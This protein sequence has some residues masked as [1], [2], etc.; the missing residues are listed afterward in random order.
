MNFLFLFLVVMGIFAVS[1]LAMGI[2]AIIK[3]KTFTS[4]GNASITYKG[5]KIK[6]PACLFKK[7]DE[8]PEHCERRRQEAEEATS[9]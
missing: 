2:G 3:N 8:P 5:E 4:C 1:L 7:G 6:C 9:D